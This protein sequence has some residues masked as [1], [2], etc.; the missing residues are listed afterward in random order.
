M[1]EAVGVPVSTVRHGELVSER[2]AC[3]LRHS[4]SDK[5]R[6]ASSA[7]RQRYGVPVIDRELSELH[8]ALFGVR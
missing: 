1:Y 5:H 8:A 3:D 6:A 4:P 2:P 7:L